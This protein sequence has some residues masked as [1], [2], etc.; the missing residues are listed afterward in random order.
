MPGMGGRVRATGSRPEYFGPPGEE[1]ELGTPRPSD[2]AGVGRGAAT[3]ESVPA[4][5]AQLVRAVG[6]GR[7]GG[8]LSEVGQ[9]RLSARHGAGDPPPSR[10]DQ[11]GQP[12]AQATAQAGRIVDAGGLNLRPS[13]G[14]TPADGQR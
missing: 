12:T 11:A 9:V 3:D 2:R 5:Q 10:Q 7:S 14:H 4:G 6:A 8:A 13:D 1:T